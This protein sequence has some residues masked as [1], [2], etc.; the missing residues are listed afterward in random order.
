MNK[1]WPPTPLGDVLRER[2]EVPSTQSIEIGEI[3]IISKI[4]FDTGK[5]EFRSDTQTKTKMIGIQPGDL[6]IS[7]INVAKGAIAIYSE[8][9]KKPAAATIHYSAYEARNDKVDKVFLWWLLRSNVFRDILARNL[10]GGIKTELK[11]KRLLPIQIP[12]PPLSEQRRIVEK[13]D[14]LAAKVEEVRTIKGKLSQK[15]TAL[16]KSAGGTILSSIRADITELKEW[17]DPQ[18]DGIQTGPFGAQLGR[19]DFCET[20]IPVLTIGNVQFNGLKTERLICVSKDKAASLS[21]YA[22]RT[23]DILF[24][25]MG[26]VGRCCIVPPEADGWLINYHIIRVA[27]DQ[28]KV[29]PRFIHWTIAASDEVEK[30]LLKTTRGATRAGVNTKIL[31]SLPCKVPPIKRQREIAGYLDSLQAK[32]DDLKALQAKTASELNAMLPSIL[33]RAFKG[34]L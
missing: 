27:L 33:D 17:T 20:G 11:A 22:V 14:R 8:N 16:L 15:T 21:R 10:P 19:N 3:R 1:S 18:R 23:G 9:E 2:R 6:V 4:G 29:D 32:V 34:E 12:L 26:T 30:Y 25:R 13:I 28:A 31:S 24:A 5:I 7:G